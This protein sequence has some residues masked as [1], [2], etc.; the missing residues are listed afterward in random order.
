MQR[1]FTGCIAVISWIYPTHAAQYEVIPTT[2]DHNVTSSSYN[3]QATI[4]DNVNGKVFVCTA[5][6]TGAFWQDL[7]L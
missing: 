7:D 2:Y 1:M 6:Y 5:T 4:F 3:Y